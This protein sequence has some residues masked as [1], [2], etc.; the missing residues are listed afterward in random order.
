LVKDFLD[1]RGNLRSF[2]EFFTK[3][4][5]NTKFLEYQNI[6]ESI[7]RFFTSA[8]FKTPTSE[9]GNAYSALSLMIK[10]I[11]SQKKG[12]RQIY[13]YILRANILTIAKRKWE[14]ELNLNDDFNW[15]G[16]YRL[17]FNITKDLKLQ[18][19][20]IKLITGY[21]QQIIFYIK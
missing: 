18:C 21:W 14:D 6:K 16:I 9:R 19:F 13:D 20:S 15:N 10:I 3:F 8:V 2:D 7:R 17:R 4:D 5:I 11:N 12:C 1:K